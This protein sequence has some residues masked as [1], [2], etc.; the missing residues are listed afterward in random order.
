MSVIALPRHHPIATLTTA[1]F[2]VA[3]I[4]TSVYYAGFVPGVPKTLPTF[5][6][7]VKAT[8]ALLA[9]AVLTWTVS[10]AME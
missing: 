8:G 6:D 4:I 7:L 10:Y 1:A 3:L 9:L 5:I 2:A